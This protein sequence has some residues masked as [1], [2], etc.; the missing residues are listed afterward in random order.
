M[1]AKEALDVLLSVQAVCNIWPKGTCKCDIAESTFRWKH[2][3]FI[4]TAIQEINLWTK[5]GVLEYLFSV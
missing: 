4:E 5:D 1:V 2:M 3:F